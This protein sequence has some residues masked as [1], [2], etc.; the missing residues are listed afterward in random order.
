MDKN[1]SIK[2]S[3]NK[4]MKMICNRETLLNEGLLGLLKLKYMKKRSTNGKKKSFFEKQILNSIFNITKY[5]NKRIKEDLSLIINSDVKSVSI[6]FQ[7]R[8]NILE[9]TK[10]QVC[11]INTEENKRSYF[12]TR[13]RM[14]YKRTMTS[15]ETTESAA[16]RGQNTFNNVPDQ[17]GGHKDSAKIINQNI[18]TNVFFR[19]ISS[20]FTTDQ[21]IIYGK[22]LRRN[23]NI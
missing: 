19:I 16:S 22:L 8:R 20:H 5:P 1:N 9:L 14:S 21:K 4:N 11:K 3:N 23:G 18:D 6:W 15:S 2:T 10:K 17:N 12:K 13:P 7:N